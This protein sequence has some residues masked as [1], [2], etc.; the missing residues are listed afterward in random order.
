MV[1]AYNLSML[2]RDPLPSVVDNLQFKRGDRFMISSGIHKGKIAE[3]FFWPHNGLKKSAWVVINST[4]T[5]LRVSS[6]LNSVPLSRISESAK[7]HPN[8]CVASPNRHKT[9]VGQSVAFSST[10][11]SSSIPSSGPL[12]TPNSGSNLIRNKRMHRDIRKT[13]SAIYS[14]I[15][16]AEL[17][18]LIH[19]VPVMNQSIIELRNTIS[20]LTADINDLQIVCHKNRRY[21]WTITI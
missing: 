14:N 21:S 11:V 15:S 1:F 7:M 19:D 17:R 8:S 10:G 20:E 18:K 12:N 13:P 9:N 4:C 16:E 5:C 3:F 2:N 6:L